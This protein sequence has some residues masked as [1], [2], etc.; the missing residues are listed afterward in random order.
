MIF[1]MPHNLFLKKLRVRWAL[2]QDELADLLGVHQSSVSRYELGAEHPPL[3]TAL[4][5][6]VIFGRLPHRTFFALYTVVEEQ[7]MTRA[8]QLER[9]IHDRRDPASAK[10]RH[11]LDS[12]MARATNRDSA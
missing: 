2:S 8:A 11:L 12:M 5:L 3:A 6:Q 9:S 7:V 10:K 1:H 4:A